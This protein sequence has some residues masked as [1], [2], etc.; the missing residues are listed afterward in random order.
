MGRRH[1]VQDGGRRR[2]GTPRVRSRE[3]RFAHVMD[4]IDP[5][6]NVPDQRG[7]SGLGPI[8]RGVTGHVRRPSR[9]VLRGRGTWRGMGTQTVAEMFEV[10]PQDAACAG[11]AVGALQDGHVR[12]DGHGRCAAR[13]QDQGGQGGRVVVAVRRPPVVQPVPQVRGCPTHEAGIEVQPG[14]MGFGF[15]EQRLQG[16]GVSQ[17]G[18]T[19]RT[20]GQPVALAF[21]GVAFDPY[22][23][24]HHQTARMTRDGAA[25]VLGGGTTATARPMAGGD[26][27]VRRRGVGG[28]HGVGRQKDRQRFGGGL[29]VWWQWVL[30]VRGASSSSS[31]WYTSPPI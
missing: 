22:P 16:N 11:V 25:F 23:V 24:G 26:G 18:L 12:G 7:I 9:N 13:G 1:H 14:S 29:N 15:A 17:V 19:S 10:P 8:L 28:R 5:V 4:P 31:S 3:G 6:D 30:Y 2:L 27:L 20:R 21:G